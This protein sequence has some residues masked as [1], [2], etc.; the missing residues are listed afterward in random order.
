[1]DPLTLTNLTLEILSD[2]IL[3]Q[4][5]GILVHLFY[6]VFSHCLSHHQKIKG[7]GIT[8]ESVRKVSIERGYSSVNLSHQHIS[9]FLHHSLFFAFYRDSKK[10]VNLICMF[11]YI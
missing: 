6:R 11:L 7:F 8:R 3:S 1:M 9:F 2:E 5:S 4:H 10:S